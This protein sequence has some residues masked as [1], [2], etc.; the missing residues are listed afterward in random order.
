MPNP[1]TQLLDRLSATLTALRE[2]LSPSETPAA[3]PPRKR[4][5]SRGTSTKPTKPAAA[6]ESVAALKARRKAKT[7]SKRLALQGKYMAAVRGLS[8]T[9]KTKVR[10]VLAEQGVEAA[11]TLA[12]SKKA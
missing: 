11:I 8:A 12:L 10:K 4:K 3:R 5:A 2:A 7:P 6:V 1:V 9:D